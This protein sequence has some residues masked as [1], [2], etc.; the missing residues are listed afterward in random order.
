MTEDNVKV[1]VE[2]KIKISQS[3]KNMIL[4]ISIHI[5]YKWCM[6][7]NWIKD[8]AAIY[9]TYQPLAV[10]SWGWLADYMKVKTWVTHCSFS[11]SFS[12][13]IF[14]RINR[15]FFSMQSF[16]NCYRVDCDRWLMT[17][18]NIFHL[19]IS[20]KHKKNSDVSQAS[21]F[22]NFLIPFYLRIFVENWIKFIW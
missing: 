21:V 20:I 1:T 13:F 16:C 19:R 10:T 18:M 8:D 2:R 5:K 4:Y 7:M 17:M 12:N 22:S 11:L 14:H 9:F 6:L 3:R 15:I